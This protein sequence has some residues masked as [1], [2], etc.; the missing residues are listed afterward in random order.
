MRAPTPL[1]VDV[2]ESFGGPVLLFG[3][4][5]F[6]TE[7]V[8]AYE[9]GYR[10]QP[11]PSVSWSASAFYDDYDDLRT[12]EIT[13]VTFFP[14]RWGNLIE[15]STYGVEIWGNLQVTKWW[16]LSPGFRSLHK[17]LSFKEGALQRRG[18]APG[19]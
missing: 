19:G 12:V 3:N 18:P 5:D 14:L 13:P 1:D 2:R 4:P 11:H 10:A 9:L 8:W 15:G 17:R 16:R 6:Q 7:K